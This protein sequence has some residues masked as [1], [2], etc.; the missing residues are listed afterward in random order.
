MAANKHGE[1]TPAEEAKL[2]AARNRSSLQIRNTMT[3]EW[4][5]YSIPAFLA[6]RRPSSMTYILIN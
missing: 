2:Y 5:F 4:G 3:K 1:L 6:G